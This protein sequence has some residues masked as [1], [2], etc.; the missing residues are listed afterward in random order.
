MGF[1]DRRDAKL[2]RNAD[3]LH[4]VMGTIMPNRADNEA[5]ISEE[6]DLTLVERYLSEKTKQ[7]P[8]YKYN[9]FQFVVTAVLHVMHQ[10]PKM[11]C[12]YANKNYYQRNELT[13]AFMI[14]KKFEDESEEGMARLITGPDWNIDKVHQDIY[15]Q[16]SH[17]RKDKSGGSTEDAMNIVNKFPRFLSKTVAALARFFDRHGWIPEALI[18]EDPF[19]ASV[20]FSN[21]GSIKM[22]SGYHHLTNWGTTSVFC[23]V[24]IIKE[25]EE[26]IDGKPVKKRILP[27]GITVDERIADG[28]Y[29]AKTMR[30][31]REFFKHPE[32]IE[33]PFS[34]EVTIDE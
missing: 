1:F 33:E 25:V 10:R 28:Y 24:G 26:M 30:M 32:L 15:R 7:D 12:F 3:A 11:N 22:N 20:T 14:K 29:F 23:I 21:L 5:Y 6:L 4:F 16:V 18:R 2:L 17:V 9:I 13:A 34:K 19:Y 8:E 31:L 27:L